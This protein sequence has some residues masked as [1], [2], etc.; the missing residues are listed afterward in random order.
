MFFLYFSFHDTLMSIYKFAFVLN[1]HTFLFVAYWGICNHTCIASCGSQ[2]K[3]LALERKMLIGM[4][5][6]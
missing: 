5:H 6:L 3:L 1:W 2:E 4:L